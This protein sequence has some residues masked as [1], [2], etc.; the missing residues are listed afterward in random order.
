MLKSVARIALLIGWITQ[1]HAAGVAIGTVTNVSIGFDNIA[2]YITANSASPCGSGWFYM[3]TADSDD[4]TV[5][6]V[7]AL[8]MASWTTGATVIINGVSVICNQGTASRF[9]SMQTAN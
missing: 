3:F 2:V 1:A 6:R 9:T 7:A 5:N 4:Q 8:A